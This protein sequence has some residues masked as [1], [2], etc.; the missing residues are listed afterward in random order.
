MAG[1]TPVRGI[2]LV[3][4]A[5]ASGALLRQALGARPELDV[6]AEVSSTLQAVSAAQH[7]KPALM[8]MDVRLTD[9][10]GHDVLRSIHATSPSTRVVLLAQA[11]V[12][13]DV[14]G[15]SSW[16]ARLVDLVVNPVRAESLS[17]R[18][19][20]TDETQSVP[21]A[22][23]F[24]GELLEQWG[25]GELVPTAQLLASE[26]VANAVKHVTG[27]CAVEVT[28]R[29]DLVRIAVADLGRG[30]P[31]LKVLA[32]ANEN[33]RGLH[34]VSALSTAWGVDRLDDGGKLVWA[35]LAP[36]TIGVM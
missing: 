15:T 23:G 1:S 27:P 10:A 8:L 6:L 16:T 36:A 18:L 3:Q 17:A 32:P 13:D 4:T 22:R 30:M 5:E 7:L 9:L 11:A 12:V 28:Q 14:P 26:L 24:V 29:D 21:L 2:V 34:I 31:D 19:V 25:L 33:G 20:L 35:D